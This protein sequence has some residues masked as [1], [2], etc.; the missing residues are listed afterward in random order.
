MPKRSRAVIKVKLN[1]P[2]VQEIEKISQRKKS[3][4]Q[5][6]CRGSPFIWEGLRLR[7]FFR[8]QYI[9]RYLTYKNGQSFC[10]YYGRGNR[11]FSTVLKQGN[12]ASPPGLHHFAVIRVGR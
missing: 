8:W 7:S 11:R 2:R 9:K 12:D 10:K 5:K 1:A 4:L 3:V 6:P